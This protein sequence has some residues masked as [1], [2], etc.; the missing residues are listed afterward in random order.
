MPS[1]VCTITFA[2]AG[3][4]EPGMQ[5]IGKKAEVGIS[6][7]TLRDGKSLARRGGHSM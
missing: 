5:Q 3:E 2:E 6:L 1:G 4:N 7:K